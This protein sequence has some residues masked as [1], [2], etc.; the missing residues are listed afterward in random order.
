MPAKKYIVDLNDEERNQLPDL[1]HKGT[2]SARKLKRAQIV[3][4]AAEG[5]TDEQIIIALDTSRSTVERTGKRFVEGGVEKALNDDPRPGAR[6]KLDGRGEAYL[7]ALACSDPPAD[8]E[9][10]ALRLLADRL[11]QM[12][13]VDSISHE[14]VRQSLKKMS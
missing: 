13:V 1:T 2:V 8:H 12:G 6:L 3:L 14:T 5:W 11:V 9:H 4:K 10:W 7:I